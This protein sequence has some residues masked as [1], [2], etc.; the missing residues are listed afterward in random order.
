AGMN[1]KIAESFSQ[2]QEICNQGFVPK[3]VLMDIALP[4]ADG[5]ECIKWLKNKFPEEKIKCVAQTAHVLQE[6]VKQYKDAKF[7]DFIAKP[8]KKEELIEIITRNI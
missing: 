7:D 4:D 1:Y 6:D 3:V 8:Y 2:M 5:F